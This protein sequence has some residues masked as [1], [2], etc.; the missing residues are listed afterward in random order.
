MLAYSLPISKVFCGTGSEARLEFMAWCSDC[1][2]AGAGIGW[3]GKGCFLGFLMTNVY[4]HL[5]PP[6]SGLLHLL[7]KGTLFAV[8]AH[9]DHA[10]RAEA[11]ENREQRCSFDMG[12]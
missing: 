3:V 5:L 1:T 4:C 7:R 8:D 9:E 11:N 2:R 12:A 10:E 6:F